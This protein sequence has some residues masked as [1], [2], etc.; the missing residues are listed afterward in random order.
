MRFDVYLKKL[1]EALGSS[2]KFSFTEKPDQTGRSVIRIGMVDGGKSVL[3]AEIGYS[4]NGYA[5]ASRAMNIYRDGNKSTY[6]TDG[7][8][9]ASVLNDYLNGLGAPVSIPAQYIK[10]G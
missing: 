3:L 1:N 10:H 4:A 2:K 6:N 7:K 5:K 8:Y 9:M